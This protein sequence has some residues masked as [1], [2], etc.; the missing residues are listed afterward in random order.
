MEKIK[1]L[2]YLIC[3]IVGGLVALVFV[4][5]ISLSSKYNS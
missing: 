4:C 2:I 3:L 1:V 5:S